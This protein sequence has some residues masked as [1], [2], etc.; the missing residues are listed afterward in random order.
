MPFDPDE[1]DTGT[2]GDGYGLHLKAAT[3]STLGGVKIGTGLTISSDGVLSASETRNKLAFSY[4]LGTTNPDQNIY[5]PAHTVRLESLGGISKDTVNEVV[6]N[7]EV[8][9]R[10]GPVSGISVTVETY[11]ATN[12]TDVRLRIENLT[13]A[14]IHVNE[15]IQAIHVWTSTAYPYV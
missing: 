4:K 11:S 1:F 13:T 15:Y 2:D 7:T 9:S 10:E 5:V 8:V 6:S 12:Q 3:D 14:Q